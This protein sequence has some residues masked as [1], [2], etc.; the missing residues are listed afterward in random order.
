MRFGYVGIVLY[1]CTQDERSSQ[2]EATIGRALWLSEK[3]ELAH[4][5]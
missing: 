2:S 5:S 4:R 3:C 1:L